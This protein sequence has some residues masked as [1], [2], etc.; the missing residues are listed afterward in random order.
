[1]KYQIQ[2]LASEVGY[3]GFFQLRRF[4][5]R[6]SLY[7][8]GWSREIERE[9]VER[10]QAASVLLYDPDEDAVV[11]I[12]QFRIGAL[13][14]SRGAW[15]L[16]VVGGLVE[17]GEDPCEVA[18]REA[19][20]EAGCRIL[21]M[22]SICDFYVSPGTA[23]ERIHLFC[24]RVDATHAGGIHGIAEEGEDIRVEVL[25]AEDAIGELYSGRVNST[26]SII[27]LQWL[28]AHR[29]ELRKRW[30]RRAG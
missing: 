7:A 13:E 20:E 14:S 28:A 18:R 4:R 30:C 25:G 27:A 19:R 22:I 26:S 2:L 17:Q 24:A 9:R 10:L 8:G 29:P 15:L 12:E 1:M 21:D 16:E 11:M 23:T 5:L 6:H 3:V